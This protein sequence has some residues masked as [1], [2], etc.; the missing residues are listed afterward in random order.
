MSSGL[1]SG[2]ATSSSRG[3]S[4]SG[5]VGSVAVVGGGVIGLSCAWRAASAGFSVVVYDPAP[6]SGASGVAGGMLAPVTEAVPGEEQVLELGMAGLRRW[7]DF[8]AELTAAGADPGLLTRGT[9]AVAVDPGDRAELD[10]LGEQLARMGQRVEALDGR[11]VRRAEPS[12][13][14][15]VRRALSVPGDLAV[16]N[17]ALL[18]ALLVAGA[19]AGVQLHRQRCERLPRADVVVLAAGAHSAALHP[20]LRE[21]VRPVKG[22]ILRLRARA[23]TPAPPS[24]TVR[25]IVGGRRSYLVPRSGGR[26]V[27]GA[28]QREA[29]FDTDVTAGG[30]LELL[31]DA[32]RVLPALG[33]YALEETAAGLRPGSPD[34]LPVIGALEPGVIAATGH[35]RHGILLAPLTA[36]AVL[37]LLRGDP[38]PP[39][40]AG[41]RPVSGDAGDSSDYH[42]RSERSEPCTSR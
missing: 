14:P 17:R 1:V 29:G 24:R 25:A 21:V 35:H 39:E 30:V 19:R 8:A 5:S 7:P 4:G 41:L 23:G 40:L 32:E 18:D 6:G 12:L 27:L 10:R 13:G 33:E 28:T 20:A 31:S 22:E 3:S 42:S 9:L 37:A 11:A 16:D 2:F 36:E 38:L 34:N 26:V 15:Q